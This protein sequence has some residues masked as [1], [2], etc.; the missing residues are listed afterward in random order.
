MKY[1]FVRGL[2]LTLGAC[3]IPSAAMAQYTVGE[4]GAGLSSGAYNPLPN[5]GVASTMIPGG[6]AGYQSVGTV[7]SGVPNAPLP[8]TASSASPFSG[9]PAPSSNGPA[10]IGN[11]LILSRNSV[12]G[13]DAEPSVQPDVASAAAAASPTTSLNTNVSCPDTCFAPPMRSLSPWIFGANAL[14]FDRLDRDCMPLTY[15][16][17]DPTFPILC[18][19]LVDMP[20]TGGFEL[21]GGRYFG[22]GRYAVIGSYWG[23]FSPQQHASITPSAGID[24]TSALPFT[25][26]SPYGGAT[27]GLEMSSQWVSDWFDQA[28]LHRVT[29]EQ[30]FQN[31]EVNFVSFALGGG[32]RQ[33]FGNDCKPGLFGSSCGSDCGPGPTG[34]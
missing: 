32:A 13:Q 28:E 19:Q 21:F 10:P 20:T 3:T 24:L 4:P 12:L 22:C 34:A 7:G 26:D 17:N 33:P 23:V 8:S 11:N 30:S 6:T 15:N 25:I 18:T 16:S 27:S 29:R 2:A 14:V 5:S 9:Y 31:A 1:T